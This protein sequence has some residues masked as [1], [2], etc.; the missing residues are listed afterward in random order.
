MGRL[1]DKVFEAVSAGIV[2]I[3]GEWR[4][5]PHNRLGAR[6]IGAGEHENYAGKLFFD[7]AVNNSLGLKIAFQK[8]L[9]DKKTRKFWAVRSRLSTKTKKTSGITPSA[10]STAASFCPA[11]EVHLY[12][13]QG[14]SADSGAIED[15][16]QTAVKLQTMIGQMGGTG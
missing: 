6:F 1:S 13:D 7:V 11:V 10:N 12:R 14:L 5:I 16:R 4:I 3:D 15:S 8:V 2:H 9:E